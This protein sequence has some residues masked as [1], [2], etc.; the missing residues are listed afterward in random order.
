MHLCIYLTSNAIHVNGVGLIQELPNRLFKQGGGSPRDASL[1]TQAFP[2]QASS[3]LA[4]F[5]LQVQ[6]TLIHPVLRI[7][8]RLNS[9]K[10]CG[11]NL[12][13]LP[14]ENCP[15]PT[16]LNQSS[17]TNPT[18]FDKP[19]AGFQFHPVG[20]NP[21]LYRIQ[22]SGNGAYISIRRHST[23]SLTDHYPVMGNPPPITQSSAESVAGIFERFS[24]F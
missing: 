16:D 18:Q 11:L 22:L 8:L 13:F 6:R 14:P 19:P 23:P 17:P 9:L 12:T 15:P 20:S 10:T 1:T 21:F 2:L 24:S 4:R 3:R 5:Y 7:K